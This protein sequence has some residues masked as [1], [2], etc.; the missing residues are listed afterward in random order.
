MK[1]LVTGALTQDV[2]DLDMFRDLGFDVVY[3]KDERAELPCDPAEFDAVVC[4]GLFLYRD[5]SEFANLKLIQLTS[6]GLD[7]VPVDE[8]KRRGI[9]LFN[10]RG[11]Y[12]APMAEYVLSEVL[13]VYKA[14]PFYRKNQ[15]EKK[16]NK[17]RDVDELVGKTV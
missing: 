12:S 6:A 11:V 7:R 9:H 10:A 1:L 5:I 14:K 3:H 15:L 16:W 13:D 8:I 2:N 4:N 17:K